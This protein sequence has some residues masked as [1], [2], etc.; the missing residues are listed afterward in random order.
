MITSLPS[1]YKSPLILTIPLV[2]PTPAGWGSIHISSGPSIYAVFP[3]PLETETPIPVVVNLRLS[4][5]HNCTKPV[6]PLP[7]VFIPDERILLKTDPPAVSIPGRLVNW[8][9]SPAKE[10]A[11]KVVPLKVRLAL[12]WSSPLAPA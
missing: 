5:C 1:T 8:E 2:V 11:V 3:V 9:P 4:W 10:L 6:A 12:S 7:K